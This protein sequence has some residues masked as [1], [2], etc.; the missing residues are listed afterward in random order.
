MY[1]VFTFFKKQERSLIFYPLKITL[2]S[3][4]VLLLKLYLDVLWTEKKLCANLFNII[5]TVSL[6]YRKNKHY[7]YYYQSSFLWLKQILFKKKNILK[8][9]ITQIFYSNSWNRCK[10][11]L[12]MLKL[13]IAGRCPNMSESLIAILR[14]L[15]Y[16]KMKWAFKI[17]LIKRQAWAVFTSQSRLLPGWPK[18]Y[19]Q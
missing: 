7:Y 12:L 11:V 9:Q 19:R 1:S 3:K 15:I 6:R 10:P 17:K 16:F 4:S 8:C 14:S 5:K 18:T 2:F 13:L